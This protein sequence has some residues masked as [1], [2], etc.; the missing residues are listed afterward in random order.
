[1][2]ALRQEKSRPW[3]ILMGSCPVGRFLTYESTVRIVHRR[4][5]WFGQP[6]VHGLNGLDGLDGIDVSSREDSL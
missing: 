2:P 4:A 3:S 5:G 1:M 6:M